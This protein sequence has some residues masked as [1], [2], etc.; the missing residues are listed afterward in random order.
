MKDR[1]V[2][3]LAAI[4]AVVLSAASCAVHEWPEELASCQCHA[5]T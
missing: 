3:I 4:L 1:T 2:K 5:Q